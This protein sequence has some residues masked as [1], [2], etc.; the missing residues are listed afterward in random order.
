MLL[1]DHMEP[2]QR[3]HVHRWLQLLAAAATAGARLEQGGASAG[4]AQG[5]AR[6]AA[7]PRRRGDG[8]HDEHGAFCG[9]LGLSRWLGARRCLAGLASHWAAGWGAQLW[10]L[11]MVLPLGQA[12]V[13]LLAALLLLVL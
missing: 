7:G 1:R 2:G 12:A 13:L 5:Q 10:L 9:R 4:A 11:R 8:G 3:L 6:R